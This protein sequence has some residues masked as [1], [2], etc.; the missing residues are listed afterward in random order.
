MDVGTG[1]SVMS[2][3]GVIIAA[4]VKM[5]PVRKNGNG[6]GNGFTNME[7]RAGHEARLVSVENT[8]VRVGKKVDDV[9]EDVSFLK[10]MLKKEK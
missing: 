10:G 3:C 9:A 8:L 2:V 5:A 4:V 1:I 6:N 7:R